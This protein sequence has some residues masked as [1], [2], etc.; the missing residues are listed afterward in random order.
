MTTDLVPKTAFAEVKLRRGAV[1]I[2]GMTKGS[3]M[4]QPLMATTL[5]FVHDGRGRFRWRSCARMLKRASE[6]SYNRISVDGDTSTND[7]LLLLANGASRRAARPEGT[8][9]GGRGDRRRDGS[10]GA[11]RSRATAKARRN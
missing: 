1:R 7:T 5:G 3:G 6:R 11:G 2:A 4:I 10:A 9:Q 8:G